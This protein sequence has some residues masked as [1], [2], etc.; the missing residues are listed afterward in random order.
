M[1]K[2]SIIMPMLNSIKYLDECMMSVLNQTI[3]DIEIIIVD[4][5]SVDG[6][7][8]CLQEYANKDARVKI[9]ASDKKS[10]GYQ[11]NMGIRAA[12]GDYI[13]FVE[14]DDY[15]VSDMYEKLFSYTGNGIVDWVKS[16]YYFFMEYPEIG[17]QLMPVKENRNI[18]YGKVFN[19]QENIELYTKE[20]YM[21][22]GIYRRDF[23]LDNN[24]FLN[25]TPGA[26]YQDMGFFLQAYMY[27]HKAVYLEDCLYCYRRDN[28][29]SS[30][31][32]KR[33]VF[34]TV[35][36]TLYV[37]D[38]IRKTPDLYKL[39]WDTH[40]RNSYQYFRGFYRELLEQDEYSEEVKEAIERYRQFCLSEDYR[41]DNEEIRWLKKGLDVYGCR[42][43]DMWNVEEELF[44][45]QTK[46]LLSKE[47]VAIMGCG[48]NGLG[49]LS[50]L[51]RLNRN[52]VICLSDNDSKKWGLQIMGIPVVSPQ[53]MVRFDL[54]AI[55]IANANYVTEIKKQLEELGVPENKIC[56]A[57]GI[58]RVRGTSVLLDGEIVPV[59]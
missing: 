58:M 47:K 6:T 48:D 1:P 53:E 17:R 19:P 54:D 10:M 39:F 11:Y 50:L 25:E 36:E 8:E 37:A 9:L 12:T 22:N 23:L 56:I 7:V 33:S 35:N 57:P 28:P 18:H 21:W 24:I 44:H 14:S 51:L 20:R 55:A 38:I 46:M 34:Y 52:T 32:V 40:C 2:I 16:D 45:E 41:C 4:A 30:M 13:G 43:K 29:G 26:A 3:K 5:G 31:H 42:V 15:V 59:C 27:A 49:V